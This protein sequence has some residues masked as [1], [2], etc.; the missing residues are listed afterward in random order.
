MFP[1]VLLSA[2]FS[3]YISLAVHFLE[4]LTS[5]SSFFCLCVFVCLCHFYLCVCLFWDEVEDEQRVRRP[6]GGGA[7]G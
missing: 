1:A 7:H 3:V 5:S 6:S 2:R 4:L